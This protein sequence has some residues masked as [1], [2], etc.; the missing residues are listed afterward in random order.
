MRRT[1]LPYCVACDTDKNY[2]VMNREYKPLGMINIRFPNGGGV[3]FNPYFM[4]IDGLGPAKAKAL[5]WSGRGWETRNIHPGWKFFWLYNDGCIPTYEAEATADYFRRL[6]E[7]MSL[8]CR[9]CKTHKACVTDVSSDLQSDVHG[10]RQQQGFVSVPGER[11]PGMPSIANSR[12]YTNQLVLDVYA[13]LNY[14]KLQGAI[15]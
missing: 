11:L 9:P 15:E 14:P 10:Y 12:A 6:G 13:G 4:Y 8:P 1:F 5:S 3:D 2:V 7:L